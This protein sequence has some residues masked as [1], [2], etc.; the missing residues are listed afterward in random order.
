L[1]FSSVPQGR[2]DQISGLRI[3]IAVKGVNGFV[4]AMEWKMEQARIFHFEKY[5]SVK[6]YK[7]NIE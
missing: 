7:V 5:V 2:R 1:F 6:V 4:K 3:Q